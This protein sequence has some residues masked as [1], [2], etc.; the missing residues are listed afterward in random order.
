MN[1]PV[2]QPLGRS[3]LRG[4]IIRS[5]RA[6][7]FRVRNGTVLPPKDLS[8]ERIRGLHGA[9]VDHRIERAREGLSRK[10]AE[11]L[12][13]IASGSEVVPSRI[14]PR[15]VEVLPDSEQ[16]LLFRY[17]SLHWSIP[18]SSGYGRR[19]RFL[20]VDEQNGKLIG[21]IGLGD[22]VYSLG[23]RDEWIGWTL[24]DRKKRLRNVMDAFVLGAVPPYSFLLCG[25]LVAMLAASDTVRDVFKRKYGGAR[26]VIRRKVHDGRL[27]LITTT[28]ALGRSSVYNRLRFRDRLIYQRVGFTKGSGDF[29]FSNGLY[30]AITEFAE[31]HCQPTAKQKRWG[32]G[33][34]NRREVIK[35]CL[36]A[37]GLSSEWVYHGI[38]RE[39]FVVPLARNTTAFLRGEHGRLAWHHQSENQIFDYFRDRW[40]LP[41][42]L[43]DTRF[44]LW[45]KDDWRMWSKETD[46]HG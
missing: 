27:A 12:Q 35:K 5:L 45:C 22:P 6:Q 10:E 31:Q 39:V 34:R 46:G 14:Y 42:A 9:A 23:P 43:W 4:Q 18:I 32:T 33:F 41:R 40:M 20:V 16:E 36:P 8:K 7:G 15:L 24:S 19:L 11:L 30:G 29:H 17:A 3:D 37:L 28:S 26:S 2:N 25:K 38:K 1:R 21:L 13:R 44:A